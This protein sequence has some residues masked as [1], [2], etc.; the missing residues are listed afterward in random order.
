MATRLAPD[1]APD[2]S[3]GDLIGDITDGSAKLLRDEL[4]LARAESVE[5]L[6]ALKRGAVVLGTGLAI[7]L[8][9]AGVATAC[10]VLVIAEFLLDGRTW[11]AAL[12]VAV[13]LGA[14]AWILVA[15]AHTLLSGAKLAPD[16]TTK[17]LKETAAWLRHPTKSAVR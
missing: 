6:V 13:V 12:A 5:S 2:R 10:A 8:L 16:E 3:L 9:A 1:V 14:G 15:R 7:G 11:L 4:R 17:S